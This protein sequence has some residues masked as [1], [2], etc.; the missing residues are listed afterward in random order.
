MCIQMTELDAR[1]RAE[2]M[3]KEAESAAVLQDVHNYISAMDQKKADQARL[4]GQVQLVWCVV[5]GVWRACL[6]RRNI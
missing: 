6:I 5:C 4:F 2:K 3:E 1:R